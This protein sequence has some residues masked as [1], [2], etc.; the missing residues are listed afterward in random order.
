[1]RAVL[2]ARGRPCSSID[3]VGN[4]GQ[5]DDRIDRPDYQGE[6]EVGSE[7]LYEKE[8]ERGDR[9]VEDGGGT[10]ED[11]AVGGVEGYRPAQQ[12]AESLG[13]GS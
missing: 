10:Q 3:A 9:E 11:S 13:G 6:E 1:M 5:A 4:E 2:T 12:F 8:G 7:I